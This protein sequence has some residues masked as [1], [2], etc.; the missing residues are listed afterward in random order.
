MS[1][2]IC[3]LTSLHPRYDSRIFHKQCVSLANHG[4]E[5]YLVVN[6]NYK[7]EVK[8]KVNII[9]IKRKKS[10][11]IS[12]FLFTN[13]HLYNQAIK[14]N[15]DIYQIHDP[16]LLSIG[17][18]LKKRGKKVIFD[19][20]EDVPNQILDKQWIP[21]WVRGIVSLLYRFFEKTIAKKFDAIISVTPHI[22][23]RFKK[24]NSSSYLVT[25]YPIVNHHSDCFT[26]KMKN[27]SICFAGGITSQWC[28]INIINAITGINN[29]EY[30]LAGSID[31]EYFN[32]LK[33]L[34][35]WPKVNYRGV[36]DICDVKKMYQESSVGMALNHSTQAGKTGTLGNTKLFEYME[37]GLPVICTNYTLWEEIVKENDC[38]VAVDP[39][40][41]KQIVEAI[42]YLIEN[43]IKAKVMGEN[44]RNAILMK[45]NWESQEKIL[46][47]LYNS[48]S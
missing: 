19:S 18:K 28:H 33:L 1:M 25:N 5:T 10:S 44:G 45:Y 38:G 48:L 40:S 17:Y 24:I 35:G 9:S 31:L 46:L 43:P 15:A 2:R 3:H 26:K 30:N 8:E 21:K 27:R 12:R 36:L 37:S 7:D 6:D 16:E 42:T 23:Q 29:I 20:H 32:K 13:G 14:I 47:D 34:E 22:V 4:Y 39:N 11:R 41:I